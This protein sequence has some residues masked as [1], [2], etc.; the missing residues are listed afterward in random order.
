MTALQ[1]ALTAFFAVIGLPVYLVGWVP[2]GTAL[3]YLTLAVENAGG[4][5]GRVTVR[6][7]HRAAGDANAARAGVMDA[8]ARTV[9]AGGVCLTLPAGCAVLHRAAAGFQ[10][11]RDGPGAGGPVAGETSF[12]L[13]LYGA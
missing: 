2:A 10:T 8:L 4:A 7:W 9:P 11:L 5:R 3:P 1:Q 13:A 6:N 12:D